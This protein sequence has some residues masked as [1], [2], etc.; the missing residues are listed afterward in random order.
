[1]GFNKSSSCGFRPTP[2]GF[3]RNLRKYANINKLNAN[4]NKL[5]ANINKLSIYKCIKSSRVI[6][7]TLSPGIGIC[8]GGVLNY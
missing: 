8:V 4:I 3:R 1:V 5:N 2:T 7:C 6:K